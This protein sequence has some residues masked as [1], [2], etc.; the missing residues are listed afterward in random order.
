MV[1]EPNDSIL[2][3]TVIESRDV[4][5]DE[6]RFKSIPRLKDKFSKQNG[7]NLDKGKQIIDNDE[8]EVIELRRSKRIK[9]KPLRYEEEFFIYLMEGTRDS[10][11]NQ[12]PYCYNTE[13]DP[14]TFEEAMKSQ[15]AAFWKEEINDEMDSIIG[16]NTWKLVDL[17]PGS[18]P[19]GCKWIF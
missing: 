10:V 2:I 15:D 8:Q 11:I 9:R 16:N 18:K 4:I 19:I 17:P 12:I 13:S 14:Q 6:Q 5:F 3:N 7:S 1:I